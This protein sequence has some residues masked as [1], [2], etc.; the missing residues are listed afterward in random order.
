[1]KPEETIATMQRE[2]ELFEASSRV[3]TAA[4]A[5]DKLARGEQLTERERQDME[6]A[7]EIIKYGLDDLQR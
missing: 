5:L 3:Q 6:Y 7:S 4:T 1:M 2:A